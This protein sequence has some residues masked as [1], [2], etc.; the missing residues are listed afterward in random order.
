MKIGAECKKKNS[1]IHPLS[2][3]LPL[4]NM[5]RSRKT[6]EERLDTVDQYFVGKEQDMVAKRARR[7]DKDAADCV[8]VPIK[9]FIMICCLVF[10][11]QNN[12]WRTGHNQF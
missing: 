8:I 6:L 3:S 7:A 1:A 12:P 4:L 11:Y 5:S 9:L 2:L 10:V